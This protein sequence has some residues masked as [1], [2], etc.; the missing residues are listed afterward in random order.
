MES[1]IKSDDIAIQIGE[2]SHGANIDTED[3]PT[4]IQGKQGIQLKNSTTND[5]LA[6]SPRIEEDGIG[7]MYGHTE[8]TNEIGFSGN[9]DPNTT[10]TN[11]LLNIR[12][13]QLNLA[14]QQIYYSDKCSYF[15][16][17]LLIMACILIFVTIIDGFKVAN[18]PLFISLEFLLNVLIGVDFAC[19]VKLVGCER[20][21]KDAQSGSIKWW[22]VFDALVVTCC[23]L[24][25]FVAIFTK[26][27][28]I[29][30]LEQGMEEFLIV[31]WC[32]W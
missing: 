31:M 1:S 18:S 25:F 11:D 12:D 16:I 27:S 24:V 4:G 28:P 32:I 29:R 6:E 20:Y 3:S 17:M 9:F 23:N 2:Q 19:R 15:Y 30:G 22:N 10:Q 8:A 13:N 5:D 14:L 26:K 21:F 7:K